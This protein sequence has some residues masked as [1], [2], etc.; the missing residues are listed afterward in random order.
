MRPFFLYRIR[1]SHASIARPNLDMP[2]RLIYTLLSEK[3]F[4]NT[5]RSLTHEKQNHL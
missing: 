3:G 4:F 1:F 5:S 2:K